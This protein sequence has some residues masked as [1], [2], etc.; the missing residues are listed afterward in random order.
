LSRKIDISTSLREEFGITAIAM[1]LQVEI[2]IQSSS[3]LGHQLTQS[4]MNNFEGCLSVKLH[5]ADL[6]EVDAA[7]ITGWINFSA[8]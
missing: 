5:D 6:S 4:S 7:S 1:G 8:I 2:F 3:N